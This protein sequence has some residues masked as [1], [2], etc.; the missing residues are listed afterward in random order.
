[1]TDRAK[2]AVT[3]FFAHL[4]KIN[5]AWAD[6]SWW[7]EQA[8]DELVGA[9]E[10]GLESA[11][12]AAWS[13]DMGAAPRGKRLIV[14]STAGEIYVAHWVKN[15]YTGGEA[16]LISEAQDGSQHLC[17]PVAWLPLPATRGE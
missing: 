9:M 11:D 4:N 1:M 7:G 14:E 3:V 17:K 5:P 10:A 15:P 8:K 2:F 6:F 12:R 13:T 16:W